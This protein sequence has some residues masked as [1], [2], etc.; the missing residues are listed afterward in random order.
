M[1]P[2][3]QWIKK[4]TAMTNSSVFDGTVRL[5]IGSCDGVEFDLVVAGPADTKV[6]FGVACMFEYEMGE[7]G[8]SGAG[9]FPPQLMETLLMTL[10]PPALGPRSLLVIGMGNPALLEKDTLRRAC[11]VAM[12]E[13]IR[14]GAASMAFAP[15]ILDAGH[16]DNAA[17]DMHN[18]MMDGMLSAL[19]A[20]HILAAIGLAPPP[21]LRE[22]SFNV[23]AP[24]A[25]SAHKGFSEAFTRFS[26]AK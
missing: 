12:R 10:P 6:D 21:T 23:G 5:P 11:R 17:L 1:V 15:G 2:T 4:E 26:P 24:R 14:F 9:A 13:A 25:Q 22:C 16:T 20:E 7:A 8:M 19:R 18:Q 3:I